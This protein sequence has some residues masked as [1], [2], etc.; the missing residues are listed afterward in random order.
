MKPEDLEALLQA[1][2][3]FETHLVSA[4]KRDAKVTAEIAEFMDQSIS[5]MPLLLNLWVAAE[6]DIQYKNSGAMQE[7]LKALEEHKP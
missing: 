5:L 2:P 4:R 7:A 3:K 1:A 6:D